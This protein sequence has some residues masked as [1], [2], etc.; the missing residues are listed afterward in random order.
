VQIGAF[1]KQT[2]TVDSEWKKFELEVKNDPAL[3]PKGDTPL[4]VSAKGPGTLW[5]D[6]FI[7]Y[8]TGTPKFRPLPY[9]T[10]ALKEFKPGT[11]RIWDGLN[12]FTLDALLSDGFEGRSLWEGER[13]RVDGNNGPSLNTMLELCE[14]TG[15]QPWLTLYPL[16]TE[17]E[18]QGLMEYLGAPADT[19]YGKLRAKHGHPEPWTAVFRNITL[20]C[21]N[22]SWNSIFMPV[23]YPSAPETYGAIANRMFRQM[24]ASPYFKDEQITFMLNGAF[25]NMGWTGR[26][27]NTCTEAEATDW[28]LY[29]GGADGLTVL[30]SDDTDLYGKQL[31]YSERIVAPIMEEAE[32]LLAGIKTKTGRDIKQ[33]V[34][35]GGPGY[36]LPTPGKTHTESSETVGK[37]LATGIL[38]LDAFMYNLSHGFISM[39]YYLF[40]TGNNWTT[41]NNQNEMIPYTSWLALSL[42]NRYCTGELMKVEPVE[43]KTID[44]PTEI[45]EKL[46]YRGVNKVKKTIKAREDIPLVLCYAFRDGKQHAFLLI[47]R[48][49]NEARTVQLDLP[50]SPSPAVTIY[51]L[52]DPD[53]RTGNRSVQN[54]DI[55]TEARSDFKNGCTI[56]LPPSSAFVIVN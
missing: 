19:G 8:Q 23:A 37:S 46:D 56:T 53:P 20:E 47:N 44:F 14:Q 12:K 54:V 17:E 38:T 39:N 10:K 49:Y 34:Y 33:A 18:I 50:Y 26:A 28:G 52:T 24:K 55:Q 30:G 7:V 40:E 51:K 29:Y 3:I 6:N 48:A 15:A 36:A 4:Q 43:I 45:A 1:A 22:E 35:E 27:L 16:Y 9:V 32:N 31:L 21:A 42:R 13:R 2:F 41:H 25:I 5:I 11:L